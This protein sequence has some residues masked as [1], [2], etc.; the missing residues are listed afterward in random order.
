MGCGTLMGSGA[1]TLT[2]PPT[3]LP[4][5]TARKTVNVYVSYCPDDN[6]GGG[7][8]AR[9]AQYAA[10][11]N[12]SDGTSDDPDSLPEDA[13]AHNSTTGPN[14]RLD[15]IFANTT[16]P[17]LNNSTASN[18]TQKNP[19]CHICPNDSGICC[20]LFTDCGSDGHCP[21]QALLGAGYVKFGVNIVEMANSSSG[22]GGGIAF[23]GK[24][25]IAALRAP[26]KPGEY[27]HGAVGSIG[28]EADTSA[29]SQRLKRRLERAVGAYLKGHRGAARH[30]L[31]Q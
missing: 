14:Y 9:I 18:S 13:A 28:E 31:D 22:I 24:T 11:G 10:G 7:S 23:S 12:V 16:T 17:A 21:Y 15:A 2:G 6:L 8:V 19:L 3:N 4:T 5:V 25:M 27:L 1:F 20:P 29:A 26:G 30:D